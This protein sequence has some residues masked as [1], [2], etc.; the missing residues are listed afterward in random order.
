MHAL[1]L[2]EV[3]E[4]A[5]LKVKAANRHIDQM[6]AHQAPLP[7][8]LYTMRVE[9]R[10][11]APLRVPDCDRVIYHPKEPISKY[12]GAAMGDAVNNLRES[13]DY[14]VRAAVKCVGPGKQLHFPFSKER[15]FL[16]ESNSFK[17]LEK[18]FPDLAAF[19]ANKIEP[20][21]DTNLYLWAATSLCNDNKHSDFIPVVTVSKV[22]GDELKIG[23]ATISN[24]SA[25]GNANIPYG[26]VQVPFGRWP[27]ETKFTVS[28]ELLF[29]KGAIF[30]YKPVGPTLRTMSEVVGKALDD[31]EGFISPYCK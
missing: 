17:Q 30:E 27:K 25:G 26:I 22:V 20:C 11:V 12:F 16:A 8:H 14:W 24:F 1:K 31:L 23:G 6:V 3:M 10:T 2:K 15:N 18:T 19:I 29:P 4:S 9:H 7:E 13:L 28:V 5:R 21:R